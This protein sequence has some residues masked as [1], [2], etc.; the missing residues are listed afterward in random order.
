MKKLLIVLLLLICTVA[1]SACVKMDE[2]TPSDIYNTPSH[3]VTSECVHDWIDATCKISKTCI[4]CGATEGTTV[5]HKY[6]HGVCVYCQKIDPSMS[7]CNKL[8]MEL[9]PDGK[10]Y[11]V[12]GIGTCNDHSVLIPTE[13]EGKPITGIGNS[14]FKDCS[15]LFTLIIP[16]GVKEIGDHAFEGC[17]NLGD[18]LIP[19]SIN[20]VGQGITYKCSFLKY[21]IYDSV[22]Y[23]G[24]EINPYVLLYRADNKSIS[25]FEVNE[26]TKI[27]YSCAFEDCT[28][29]KSIDIPDSVSSIGDNAF[30][31]CRNLVNISIPDGISFIGDYAFSDCESL[32][33][34]S[35]PDS[36]TYIGKGVFTYCQNL[37]YNQYDNLMY[38]GNEKNPYKVLVKA[39]NVNISSCNISDKTDHILSY[40][41]S[42]C[43]NLKKITIPSGVTT[44]GEGAF[45][46]CSNLSEITIPESVS[47]IGDFAFRGCTSLINISIPQNIK[48][49]SKYMFSDCCSLASIT[50]QGISEIG[51]DAFKN[52]E[53]LKEIF[54]PDSVVSIKS[55]AFSYCGG[56]EKIEVA[57]GNK[58]YSSAGNCLII[59][60]SKTLMVG[61]KN[62]VIPEDGSVLI[63][64]G[65]AFSN[66][67]SLVEITIPNVITDIKSYAFEGCTNLKAIVIPQSVTKI[68]TQAF[69]RCPGVE[70]IEVSPQNTI[71][72]S[73]GNC[74]IQTNEKI[75]ITGCKN[76]IIPED[77]SV[78]AIGA[79][80]FSG[81]ESLTQISLP[82]IFQFGAI[83]PYAFADCINLTSIR[84]DGTIQLWA[85]ANK[86]KEWDY[87]T[88]DYKVI[89]NDGTIGKEDIFR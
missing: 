20:K 7:P 9:N 32:I 25:S 23:L 81:C 46:A 28:N 38:L 22:K 34:I 68:E 73:D 39:Q 29:L 44:I 30:L 4:K 19:D 21:N 56:L 80:A 36:V 53:S 76:S 47:H 26:K 50:L 14:A 62:S 10:S 57:P 54:I 61:C 15:I 33:N 13:Y 12:I 58:V 27:I 88:G 69:G 31:N 24:N 60:E 8:E 83:K 48:V 74:L 55:N 59:T 51:E 5:D 71:Y 1:F 87:N 52:C 2:N 79:Y 41:F 18:L 63:I 43:E 72:H 17:E 70:T 3:S 84:F 64:G 65:Y 77:G 85:L 86:N 67:K 78:S 11:T 49:I 35:I 89:C 82:A 75:L 40:A 6:R 42:S 45:V 66:C 37:K 16:E